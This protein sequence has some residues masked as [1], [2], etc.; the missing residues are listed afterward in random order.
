MAHAEIEKQGGLNMRLISTH[1]KAF[2]MNIPTLTKFNA[3]LANMRI[4][5]RYMNRTRVG[6]RRSKVGGH[7][8]TMTD[9]MS[10]NL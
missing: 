10:W 1:L 9:I 6:G 4:L 3:A 7:R 5:T 8:S 2:R